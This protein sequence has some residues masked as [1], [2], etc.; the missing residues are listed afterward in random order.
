[1]SNFDLNRLYE[2]VTLRARVSKAGDSYTADLLE[3]G[4]ER[5]AQKL[6]E[7]ATETLIAAISLK[8]NTQLEQK[9]RTEQENTKKNAKKCKK[10][11]EKLSTRPMRRKRR[12]AIP[13]MLALVCLR[14][15]TAKCI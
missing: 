6:G 3:Q 4:I 11:A 1:M 2:R 14:Y 7:E 9:A 5:I 10:Y 15:D 12:L 8:Q 13:P